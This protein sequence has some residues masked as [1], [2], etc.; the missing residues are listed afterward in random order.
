[1]SKMKVT[2]EEL[3]R[4][5]VQEIGDPGGLGIYVLRSDD[6]GWFAEVRSGSELIPG[7]G[8]QA[9][10][11]EIV[12]K[13]RLQYDLCPYSDVPPMF[14]EAARNHAR[15]RFPPGHYLRDELFRYAQCSEVGPHA[16]T[17]VFYRKFRKP[18]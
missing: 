13:L 12:A 18:S 10:V 17:W 4:K 6:G 11:D 14:A 7:S 9:A 1:M 8:F 5:I 15:L 3:L 16:P 2:A